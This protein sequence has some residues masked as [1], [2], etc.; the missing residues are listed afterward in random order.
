MQFQCIGVFLGKKGISNFQ[1]RRKLL[2]KFI[3]TFGIEKIKSFGHKAVALTDHA[4]LFGAIEF[5]NKATA[6]GIKPII[7]SEIYLSGNSKTAHFSAQKGYDLPKSGAFHL[8]LLANE[9]HYRY[10]RLF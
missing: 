3:K 2:D 4:N 9:Y 7:G 10:F 6:A 5:Y 8:V 1:E